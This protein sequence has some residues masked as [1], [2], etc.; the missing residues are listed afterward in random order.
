MAGSLLVGHQHLPGFPTALA[1]GLTLR[2]DLLPPSTIGQ[3][4]PTPPTSEQGDVSA[5][6]ARMRHSAQIDAPL[7]A[8]QARGDGMLRHQPAKFSLRAMGSPS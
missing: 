6:R 3:L 1:R 5:I 8:W 2:L 4:A 7:D